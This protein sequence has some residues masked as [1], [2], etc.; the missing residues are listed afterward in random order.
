MYIYIHIYI[1]IYREHDVVRVHSAPIVFCY[2]LPFLVP[3]QHFMLCAAATAATATYWV[4]S[5]S[6]GYNVNLLAPRQHFKL[7]IAPTAATAP[8]YQIWSKSSLELWMPLLNSLLIE[9]WSK[10]KEIEP[11]ALEATPQLILNWKMIKIDR[12]SS[13]A[14]WRLLLCISL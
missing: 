5:I 14:L 6:F 7:C 1:Y 8:N 4:A 3:Q 9:T 11:G 12:K 10:L 13:L 2:N